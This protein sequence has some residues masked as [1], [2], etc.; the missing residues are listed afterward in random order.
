[1]GGAE[2]RR[3]TKKERRNEETPFFLPKHTPK[4]H[5]KGPSEFK[6]DGGSMFNAYPREFES[7]KGL[8]N[9]LLKERF[10]SSLLNLSAPIGFTLLGSRGS[11]KHDFL[12]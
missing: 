12:M 10:Q 6:E 4:K 9:F 2:K 8:V 3:E 5:M 11:G 1:M 7:A